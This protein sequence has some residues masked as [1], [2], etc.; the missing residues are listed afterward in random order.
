MPLDDEKSSLEEK[1]SKSFLNREPT[2]LK[3]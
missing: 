2:S 1:A 3:L